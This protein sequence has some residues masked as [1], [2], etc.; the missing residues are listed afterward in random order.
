MTPNHRQD[1]TR[2]CVLRGLAGLG[3]LGSFAACSTTT[4][5]RNQALDTALALP[6]LA[7]DNPDPSSGVFFGIFREN[8]LTEVVK[9]AGV[10]LE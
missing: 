10:K 1:P 5:D 3:A 4:P 8:A 6:V 9:D 7:D 2:R